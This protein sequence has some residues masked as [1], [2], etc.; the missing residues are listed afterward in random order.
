MA[1]FPWNIEC[2][3]VH[4]RLKHEPPGR[5]SFA[6]FLRSTNPIQVIEGSTEII[7]K[8]GRSAKNGTNYVDSERGFSHRFLSGFRADSRL[9]R[10]QG[11]R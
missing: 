2:V 9:Y 4:T 10:D 11:I 8:T 5:Y 1:R 7:E 3:H 6:S